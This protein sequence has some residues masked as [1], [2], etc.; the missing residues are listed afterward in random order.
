MKALLVPAIATLLHFAADKLTGRWQTKVSDK[1]N[2]TSVL[3]KEDNTF[4]GYINKKPFT[5]GMYA[6]RGDTLS[7][8]DNGCQG[9]KGIYKII[10]FNNADSL[11]FEAISDSCTERKDGM[12]RLVLGR[13]K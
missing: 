2:V 3:F 4:E 11:R 5:S 6:L 9:I 12:S 7:F 10:F 1:G 8:T 13:V